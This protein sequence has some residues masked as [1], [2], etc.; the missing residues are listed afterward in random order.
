MKLL[1]T[2]LVLSFVIFNKF[3]SDVEPDENGLSNIHFAH[4]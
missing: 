1:I 2:C 4:I 3:V